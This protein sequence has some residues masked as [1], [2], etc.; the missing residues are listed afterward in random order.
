MK[1]RLLENSMW[2]LYAIT[3]IYAI[4]SVLLSV[5]L[6]SSLFITT[7][8]AEISTLV[9]LVQYL[10]VAIFIKIIW[11]ISEKNSSKTLLILTCLG[12]ASVSFLLS[13]VENHF[14]LFSLLAIRGF[15][16]SIFK[17]SRLVYIKTVVQQE[18]IGTVNA[19]LML[20]EFS[21]QTCG[22]FLALFLLQNISLSTICFIDGGILLICTLLGKSLNKENHTATGRTANYSIRTIWSTLRENPKLKYFSF[23]L[24]LS[25][26][27]FQSLNQIIRTWLPLSWL[28]L[29]LN[30]VGFIELLSLIGIVL[31]LYAAKLKMKKAVTSERF[32]LA[33]FVMASLCLSG[34]FL[35]K[36]L[37]ISLSI[38]LLY[39][40]FFELS[41]SY[42]MSSMMIHIEEDMVKGLLALFYSI[43]YGGLC[44]TG[45][46]FAYLVEMH[47]LDLLAH[48]VGAGCILLSTLLYQQQRR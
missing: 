19:Q 42:S 18:N 25:V 46:L 40:F 4:G 14:V 2:H 10:P 12:A 16:D 1:K 24:I 44:I 32:L 41:L 48:W 26:I 6:A 28:D 9:F 22:A 35:S 13:Q 17:Q 23:M 7:E 30:K 34:I 3:S 43:S 5:A 31:G 8:S 11:L 47:G 15:I 21:G 39:M 38:Y 20:Y 29:S 37:F 27:S 45:I 33:V 36:E